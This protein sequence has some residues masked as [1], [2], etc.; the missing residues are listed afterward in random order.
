MIK[1]VSILNS[2]FRLLKYLGEV[3]EFLFYIPSWVDFASYT[4]SH[5]NILRQIWKKNA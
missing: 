5:S 1:C 2:H 4:V 3:G